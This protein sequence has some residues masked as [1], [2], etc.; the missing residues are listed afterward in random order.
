MTSRAIRVMEGYESAYLLGEAEIDRFG[1]RGG[2]DYPLTIREADALRCAS[3]GLRNNEAAELLA[4]TP[5]AVRERWKTAQRKLRA[6]NTNFSAT[7]SSAVWFRSRRTAFTP[8]FKRSFSA[9]AG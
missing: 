6:K 8:T 9:C 1:G 3:H 2:S 5:M 7:H 4:C